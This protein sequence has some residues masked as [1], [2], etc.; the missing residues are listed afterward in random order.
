M[1]VPKADNNQSSYSTVLT[2]GRGSGEPDQYRDQ[3]PACRPGANA[4]ESQ[5]FASCTVSA[6]FVWRGRSAANAAES[7]QPVPWVF[8]VIMR[9]AVNRCSPSR[10]NSQSGLC[11]SSRWPP[12]ISTAPQPIA[13]SARPCSSISCSVRACGASSKAAASGKFGV[14]NETCG[15]N[16][17]RS[18][19]TAEGESSGSPL[20][21]A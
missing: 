20:L 21:P 6:Q 13:N 12:F 9:G 1:S 2:T 16:R 19:A 18:V 4:D 10:V 14:I 3:L 15:N 7:V 5:L 8:L 11:S 17:L